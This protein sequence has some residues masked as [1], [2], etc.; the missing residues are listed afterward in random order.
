MNHAP[1][2][3]HAKFGK[4]EKHKSHRAAAIDGAADRLKQ[5]CE[6]AAGHYHPLLSSLVDNVHDD[7][8][9]RAFTVRIRQRKWHRRY[10]AKATPLT[11]ILF[12]S[13]LATIQVHMD[14]PL[15]SDI[16]IFEFIF[17]V[18]MCSKMS[19]SCLLLLTRCWAHNV[20]SVDFCRHDSVFVMG[21]KYC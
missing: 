20:F 6:W 5:Q 10:R 9:R 13:S 11:H 8:I 19:F 1:T 21:S 4:S 16:S 14:I 7:L 3:T 12:L 17:V 18:L 15:A 2:Q